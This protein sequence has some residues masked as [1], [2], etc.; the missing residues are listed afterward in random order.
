MIFCLKLMLSA[1]L[2]LAAYSCL[3]GFVQCADVCEVAG[4]E[5]S[6]PLKCESV[7]DAYRHIAADQRLCDYLDERNAG[8]WMPPSE[9]PRSI[10]GE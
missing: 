4:K 3:T 10:Q 5:F 1:V 8:H 9:D 6:R 2:P 7:A